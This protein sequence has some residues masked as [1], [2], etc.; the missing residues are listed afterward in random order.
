MKVLVYMRDARTCYLLTDMVALPGDP[1]KREA[2]L[3]D[4]RQLASLLRR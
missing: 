1:E 2:A 4:R 3:T